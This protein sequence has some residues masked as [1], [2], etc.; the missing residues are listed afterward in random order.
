MGIATTES[1]TGQAIGVVGFLKN[2]G[3]FT[4]LLAIPAAL[5]VYF[6]HKLGQDA[7][8]LPQQRKSAAK[9]WIVFSCGIVLFLFLPLLLSFGVTGFLRG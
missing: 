2:I 5:G 8:G 1:A 7:A 4:G 3:F 9:F 6:G